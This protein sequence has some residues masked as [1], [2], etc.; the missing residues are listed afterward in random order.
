MVIRRST[1][2]AALSIAAVFVLPAAASA[3]TTP[4]LT[5]PSDLGSAYVRTAGPDVAYQVTNTS[6][7]PVGRPLAT[8]ANGS[9][10]WSDFDGAPSCP[11]DAN[12]DLPPGGVCTLKLR[13]VPFGV[14]L[15]TGDILQ[16]TF[17]RN[18]TGNPGFTTNSLSLSSTGIAFTLS[19]A[20]FDFGAQPIGWASTPATFT[21]TRGPGV[22]ISRAQI[23]GSGTDD[24]VKT[25]DNCTDT[26]V[27]FLVSTCDIHVR[28]VPSSLLTSTAS[29][30]VT[31]AD[32][33]G[34][35]DDVTLNGTGT[36]PGQGPAGPQG[37]PGPQG[38]QG[39]AGANGS[40]G[41]AGP[42]GPQGPAGPAGK[43]ICRNTL[44]VRLICDQLFPP[45]TWT[46]AGAAG[47]AMVSLDRHGVVYAR[48][49]A[50]L[51][52]GR[53][54]S[55]RLRMLRHIVAGHYRLTLGIRQHSAVVRISRSIRLR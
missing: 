24:F 50:R 35:A 7:A 39:P 23:A 5:G 28:F 33:F 38:P 47:T 27:L 11:F 32:P 6:T 20:A 15:H 25:T 13:A 34:A 49:T 8:L 43:V 29:L 3:V 30:T 26:T 36:T 52:A 42:A 51:V 21:V 14:G 31:S 55:A 18:S 16:V 19:V 22:T 17:D 2:A 41:P 9:G 44:T 45:G 37:P 46:V 40:T 53:V 4:S 1:L 48:G 10:L 12:G 54:V